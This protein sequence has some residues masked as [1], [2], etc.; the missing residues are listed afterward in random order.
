MTLKTIA[1]LEEAIRDLDERIKA[2][3]DE[4]FKATRE[5]AEKFYM[6]QSTE[7]SIQRDKLTAELEALKSAEN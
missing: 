6:D 5:D 2:S 1:E 4:Y 3:D 7:F